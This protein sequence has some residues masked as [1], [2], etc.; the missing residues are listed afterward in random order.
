MMGESPTRPA[1]FQDRPLVV[2]TPARRPA[3]SM[4][5]QLIVPWVLMTERSSSGRLSVFGGN[6]LSRS[7][8]VS[9]QRSQAARDFSVRRSSSL[10]PWARANLSAPSPTMRTWSV[11]SMT[12]RATL[13]GFLMF[14]SAATAPAVWVG[15]YMTDES[16]STTPSSLGRPP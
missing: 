15:P 14:R 10:K 7:D 9:F 16:S 2:V 1:I 4:A 11:L 3:A 5:M 13:D 8:I 6:Q 12:S